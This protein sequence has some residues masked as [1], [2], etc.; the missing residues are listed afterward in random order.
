MEDVPYGSVWTCRLGSAKHSP[1][2]T[3][4]RPPSTPCSRRAASSGRR[5]A[6]EGAGSH[7]GQLL[8]ALRRP[9][10]PIRHAVPMRVWR[11]THLGSEADR[12]T[13]RTLHTASLASPALREGLTSASA[14]RAVR[15]LRDLL[16]TP[17]LAVTDTAGCLAWDGEGA[18]HEGQVSAL[19]ATTVEKGRTQSFGRGELPCDVPG[20]AV[21][22][23]VV[24]PL[25]VDER[26]VGTLAAF[27]PY[28]TA[29]L[30]LAADETAQWV[31]GQLELGRARREPDPADGGRGARAPGA[32]QPALHLQL[33]QRDRELRA[34]RPGPGA[35]AAP[36][37]R[38]LHPLLV[39]QARRLHDPGRGAP[40]D[41]A[42]PAARAGAV[43]R[44]VVG[45][46]QHRARGA[47][48]GGAV[49]LHP[50]AGRERRPARARGR[51]G[52]GH[53]H[54]PG[55]RPRARSASS[56]SRTTVPARTRRRYAARWP[57]T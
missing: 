10:R 19:V 22:T 20:C 39:P 49:P 4:P 3:G 16:G 13:F 6:R 41:R 14:E 46:A 33:A 38:G 43:R 31:S 54:H 37:V 27:A 2:P 23:A 5:A 51:R 36:G 53:H 48:R 25:V 56:R 15:H 50:A 24:S 30:A 1:P 8:L 35:L 17:A 11:R 12:A 32:D 29:G 26:I 18:H 57:A 47:A 42:L 40:V 7:Q 34:D 55:A 9:T 21:R 45:E 52:V 28:P 44:P